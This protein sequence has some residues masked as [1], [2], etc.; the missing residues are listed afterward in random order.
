MPIERTHSSKDKPMIKH[1]IVD[2]AVVLFFWNSIE[3]SDLFF[4]LQ[5]YDFMVLF[6]INI[7]YVLFTS[8]TSLH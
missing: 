3:C 1:T 4:A 6:T 5:I 8:I 2:A 7:F